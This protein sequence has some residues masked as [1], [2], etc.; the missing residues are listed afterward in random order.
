MDG[1]G[2]LSSSPSCCLPFP[3]VPTHAR[4][5]HARLPMTPAPAMI[6]FQGHLTPVSVHAQQRSSSPC[7]E[8]E[9]D[10]LLCCPAGILTARLGSHKPAP[11]FSSFTRLSFHYWILLGFSDNLFQIVFGFFQLF[12]ATALDLVQGPACRPAGLGRAKDHPPCSGSNRGKKHHPLAHFPHLGKYS[13][14]LQ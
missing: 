13:P 1:K 4:V 5:C 3:A 10:W 14:L 2:G 7:H 9:K 8:E 6:Q 12:R 11:A